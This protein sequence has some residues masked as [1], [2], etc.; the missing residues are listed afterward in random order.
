[1]AFAAGPGRVADMFISP[2][3]A[4]HLGAATESDSVTTSPVDRGLQAVFTS[5]TPDVPMARQLLGPKV[6][7]TETVTWD[8]PGENGARTGRLALA[9]AGLPAGADGPLVLEPSPTGSSV[10]YDAELR[11]RIPLLGKKLEQMV[12]GYARKMID[13]LQSIGNEWLAGATDPADGND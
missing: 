7:I 12:E 8:D 3:F 9:L 13:A 11:V 5:P 10:V 2:G 6:T 4:D 1:M